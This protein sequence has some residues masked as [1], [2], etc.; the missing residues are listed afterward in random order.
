M[1]RQFNGMGQSSSPHTPEVRAVQ[2]GGGQ[3]GDIK[4][5]VNMFRGDVN[6]AIPLFQLPGR[7]DLNVE[8]SLAYQ[9]NV[10]NSV[11]R[12]NLEAPTGPLGLGWSMPMNRIAVVDGGSAAPSSNRYYLVQDGSAERLIPRERLQSGEIAFEAEIYRFWTILYSPQKEEWTITRTDGARYV[13]GG[14]ATAVQWSVAWG[15]SDAPN[16]TGPSA[17]SD[18]QRQVAA[19]WDLARIETVRGDRIDYEYDVMMQKVGGPGTQYQSYTKASYLSRIK[20]DFGREILFDYAPKVYDP[21]EGI[22]EYQ[23]PHKVLNK[24]HDAETPDAYQCRYETKYL[25]GIRVCDVAGTELFAY[26]FDYDLRNFSTVSRGDDTYKFLYKRVLTGVRRLAPE[27][28]ALPGYRFNYWSRDPGGG[29]PENPHPGALK[30]ITYPSGG[31]ATYSFQAETVTG[32]GVDPSVPLRHRIDAPWSETDTTPRVWFGPD[33]TVVTWY[34]ATRKALSVS[35]Y[36][37][38]GRWVT[39]QADNALEG[40][41]DLDSLAL[42]G[43]SDFFCLTFMNKSTRN[44][45]LHLYRKDDSRFGN[46]SE[47]T[48]N[49]S[50]DDLGTP[51]LI[52]AGEAYV[53][54]CNPGFS[55]G[56]YAGWSWSDFERSWSPIYALPTPPSGSNIRYSVTGRDN[57][58]LAASFAPDGGKKDSGSVEYTLIYRDPAERSG[59]GWKVA[60]TWRRQQTVFGAGDPK[61]AFFFAMAA[62]ASFAVATYI[63]AARD[64]PREV[65]YRMDAFAW[66]ARYGVPNTDPYSRSYTAPAV[67]KLSLPVFETR[68]LQDAMVANSGNLLRYIGGFDSVPQQV[69]TAQD[70]T[71]GPSASL[72]FAD[73]LDAG[74]SHDS[75]GSGTTVL[76]TFNPQ[77]PNPGGWSTRHLGNDNAVPSL[78]GDYL[79]LGSAVFYRGPRSDWQQLP[80]GLGHDMAP[81]TMENRAPNYLAYE[82]S[83]K[84]AVQVA[85]VANGKVLSDEQT[86]AS[87]AQRCHVD[88]AKLGMELAGPTMFVTYPADESFDSARSLYLYQVLNG[89]VIGQVRT[90]DV[91]SVRI[92]HNWPH[93][94]PYS[95]HY[96]YDPDGVTYNPETGIAQ[97]AKSTLIPGGDAE[98][99]GYSVTYFSNGLLPRGGGAGTTTYNHLLNGIPIREE[100]YDGSD[101]LIASVTHEF[102]VY[103]SRQTGPTG[104]GTTDIAGA[105]ARKVKET[106]VLDGVRRER[107]LEWSSYSGLPTKETRDD[108]DSAGKPIVLTREFLYGYEVPSYRDWMVG[109]NVLDISV[110]GTRRTDGSITAREVTTWIE[111]LKGRWAK[112][113][114]AR[115]KGTGSPDFDFANWSNGTGVS[116]DWVVGDR[117]LSRTESGLMTERRANVDGVV[118][119]VGYSMDALRPVATFPGA[120]TMSADGGKPGDAAYWGLESYEVNP[121][122]RVQPG[123]GNPAANIVSVDPRVGTKCLAVLGDAEQ[124]AGPQ[125]EAEPVRQNQVFILS[126]WVRTPASFTAG[127]D[128]AWY[129][130]AVKPDGTVIARDTY[131]IPATDGAW[132]YMNM[133]IDLGRIRSDNSIGAGVNLTLRLHARNGGSE[134]YHLDA[135]RIT[136]LAC[137]FTATAYGP[138]LMDIDG[139]I[140]PRGEITQNIYDKFWQRIAETGPENGR[141]RN[142]QTTTRPADPGTQGPGYNSVLTVAP[143]GSGIFDDFRTPDL[144]AYWVGDRSGSWTVHPS[145]RYLAHA[146]TRTA[147]ALTLQPTG[148]YSAYG[149]QLSVQP[150]GPPPQ[151]IRLLVGNVLAVGWEPAEGGWVLRDGQG[152]KL[153]EEAQNALDPGRWTIVVDGQVVSFFF[154]GR[155]IFGHDLG[156]TLTGSFGIETAAKVQFRAVCAFP[157]PAMTLQYKDGAGRD[158]QNHVFNSENWIISETVYDD[159]ARQAGATKP[160]PRSANE[161]GPIDD[162]VTGVDWNGD[163]RMT[164]RISDYYGSGGDGFSDDEGYPFSRTDFEPSPV[165]R[166]SE[167]SQP[168][169]ALAIDGTVDRANR[170]T[171]RLSYAA[172]K[173]LHHLPPG[174]YFERT[175]LGEDGTRTVEISNSRQQLLLKETPIVGPDGAAEGSLTVSYTYSPAGDLIEVKL[176][177]AYQPRQA[178]DAGKA[179]LT[180]ERD[181]FG[182]VTKEISYNRTDPDDSSKPGAVRYMYDRAGRERFFQSPEL[183]QA[184]RIGYYKYD[185]LGRQIEMGET[186]FD[187]TDATAPTLQTHADDPSWPANEIHWT[188]KLSYDGSG[189]H[190]TKIMHLAESRTKA[191]D[192]SSVASIESF[193]YDLSSRVTEKSVSVPGF[194]STVRTLT[195]SYDAQNRLSELTANIGSAAY[196]LA[197]SRNAYGAMTAVGTSPSDPAAYASFDYL[198]TGSLKTETLH[199]SSDLQRCFN[200]NSPVWLTEVSDPSFFRQQIAY[201]EAG[202]ASPTYDGKPAEITLTERWQNGANPLQESYGYDSLGRLRSLYGTIQSGGQASETLTYDANGNVLTVTDSAAGDTQYSYDGATDKVDATTGSA[203]SNYGHSLDGDVIGAPGRALTYDRTTGRVAT[204]TVSG[205]NPADLSYSYDSQGQRL[206]AEGVDGQSGRKRLYLRDLDGKVVLEVTKSGSGADSTCFYVHGPSGGLTAVEIDGARHFVLRDMLG[207]NRVLIDMALTMKAAYRYGAYGTLVESD[208]DPGLLRYRFTGQEFD[209]ESGL[210]NFNAR[211]YDPVLRRFYSL[212]P[213]EEFASPYL[214]AGNNPMAYKDP[215]GRALS[216]LTVVIIGA[217]VGAVAGLAAGV[218]AAV[219]NR[220]SVGEAIWKTALLTVLGAAS[221]A[222]FSAVAYGA[223]A[224]G[225]A[226]AAA[227]GWAE[228]TAGTVLA[229]SIELASW[230]VTGAALGAADGA[231][232]AWLSGADIGEAAGYGALS[233]L[234]ASVAYFGASKA[235]SALSRTVVSRSLRGRPILKEAQ[236]TA[237]DPITGQPS[238]A[239]L[240]PRF[241]VLRRAAIAESVAGFIGG[242]TSSIAGQSIFI[243]RG[244]TDAETVVRNTLLGAFFGAVR[245]GQY[246]EY[247]QAVRAQGTRIQM[248]PSETELN[249]ML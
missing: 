64:T 56:A 119:S 234:I 246:L 135:L 199:G 178:G 95:Q 2:F 47:T 207:S 33:Y 169:M 37:W 102:Q 38:A 20:D 106:D 91:A 67:E 236:V 50:L 204:V 223:A 138:A 15:S 145:E 16:W 10:Q 4:D 137:D 80:V 59:N 75:A 89:T 176:P 26:R 132:Q 182:Q 155:Q 98:A 65:D 159:L 14:T 11:D 136:P 43:R 45:N 29:A 186:A 122:W 139:K 74:V 192:D 206:T 40:E 53:M 245:S 100:T 96:R 62:G 165:S 23:D 81:G 105:W 225:A 57:Y 212:D 19:A 195:F 148:S 116:D 215:S 25:D 172:N 42:I 114:T 244:D 149:V 128:A 129:I 120:D 13:Y 61:N 77:H 60:Q 130:A 214:Y 231:T 121:G 210:Y 224:A 164:G 70:R 71:L 83:N 78:S 103:R 142:L 31:T 32:E 85:F 240:R 76:T 146:E 171:M 200:Y 72:S 124:Q 97:F 48:L 79:T 54:L 228:T 41:V 35:V 168:G 39:W 191:A 108:Y 123:N 44:Q 126:C 243:A 125:L 229:G 205:S 179:V 109:N 235:A 222:I 88:D 69:W 18:G 184:D 226:A 248:S 190:P 140:G 6:H 152:G 66:D 118:S 141:F 193:G 134:T 49:Q 249:A 110:Q 216:L 127:A 143:H 117:V 166:T 154:D 36:R 46:W 104:G 194:D 161:I 188:Q 133:P 52:A 27:G 174:K 82:Q 242:G 147:E 86:L 94:E 99:N 24:P 241:R 181:F 93:E 230:S 115:W 84:R 34:S 9:S 220:W 153:A 198:P 131:Q 162:F 22:C 150:E 219:H 203:A 21:V 17:R 87:P 202:Q 217:I 232:H 144:S 221:G 173:G 55:N 209:A 157:G 160:M 107:Q 177:N 158:R 1:I 239:I 51:T 197:Y 113:A 30:T 167:V 237:H 233:G 218:A 112:C 156:S 90:R 111:W 170:H 92:D 189:A 3:V 175:T 211:L 63:T 73:A 68:I 185:R 227:A 12:W 163:G 213:E 187:W 183:R 201:Y 208:G 238:E 101:R 196:G 28:Q 180:L 151:P 8:I 7:N 58:I 5:S 247:R